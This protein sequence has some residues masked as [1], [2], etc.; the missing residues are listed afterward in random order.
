MISDSTGSE[1]DLS[2]YYRNK[3]RVGVYL[4]LSFKE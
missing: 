4:Y 3:W 2:L 1:F